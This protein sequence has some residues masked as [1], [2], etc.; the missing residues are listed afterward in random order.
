MPDGP[1]RHLRPKEI[2]VIVAM[3]ASKREEQLL[4][5]ELATSLVEEMSDGGMGS[6]RFVGPAE[7]K[8][9]EQLAKAEFQD[10]DGVTLSITINT[11]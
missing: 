5:E 9:G 6:L 3:L 11:D 2:A 4:R 7:R 10:E 1:T 8:F